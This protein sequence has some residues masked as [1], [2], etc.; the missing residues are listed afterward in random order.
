MK[1][2]ILL[3]AILLS[4]L[5]TMKYTPPLLTTLLL[6]FMS[7]SP[8]VAAEVFH[9]TMVAS[10][11][12][13]PMEIS[14]APDG[15][16][17]VIERAGRLLRVHP[18]TGAIHVAGHVRVSHYRK[19]EEGSA[20]GRECGLLG[21]ALAPDFTMTGHIY[22]YYS[23]PDRLVNH[24]SRFAMKNAL[25]DNASEQVLL[26]VAT[27]RDKLA[28]HMAGSLLFGADGCL[29][30]ATGDNTNPFES[31]GH[32]PIDDRAGQEHA[33]AMRASSNSNDLRGKILRIRP[34]AAGYDIP[35]G[36]LFP[37]GTPATKPEIYVMGCR[38]P[39]RLSMDE[40]SNTLYWG[41]VG[42]DADQPSDRG[43]RGFDEIN[44]AA[45]AGNYGWPLVIADN[46]PYPIVDFASGKIGPM[47]DPAAPH[48]PSQF[49][50]GLKV[51]PPARPA[52]IWYP[53]AE[54]KEFP[55]MGSGGRNAMAGP[56][57][58]FD[59]S[60]RFN[61][62]GADADRT[63]ITYDWMR[64]RGWKVKLDDAQKFVR[65][66][67]LLDGLMHPIDMAIAP[68]GA[69]YV[70]EYGSEWYWN[71]NGRLRRILLLQPQPAPSIS[72]TETAPRQFTAAASAGAEIRWFVTAGQQDESVGS[73]TAITLT[74]NDVREV[75]AVATDKS[76]HSA[77]ARRTLDITTQPQITLRLAGNPAKAAFGS[78]LE[79]EVTGAT[80]PKSIVTRARYIPPTGHDA[81]GPTLPAGAAKIATA[82][83]CFAC[84]QVDAPSV[85]PRYVDVAMRYHDDPTAAE[86]LSAKLKSGGAGVWGQIP[87]P[88]Q[89]ALT[90]PEAAEIIPA[91]LALTNG[92]SETRG[93]ATGSLR[94]PAAPSAA[95]PGGAW[96]IT[97]EALGY[98]SAKLRIG[99]E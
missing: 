95:A 30:L 33:N 52:F 60:R 82:R 20:W 2:T 55:L 49:N 86:K 64:G 3:S 80:D 34:T 28:T 31:G 54:S 77:F 81:G 93:N 96:E 51:L 7:V 66:E 69:L 26:T 23:H 42:P 73:G 58:Y 15:D 43:P 59:A 78:A 85:G 91:I 53:Y 12:Q 75:R 10:D 61:L 98:N 90:E 83:Q 18:P 65:M 99:A 72:I 79:F 27:E 39:F 4:K 92:M 41:E 40:K 22:L 94:L 29:Y 71:K 68:D 9:Q 5:T 97:A 24:L 6:A 50:T 44:Q 14:V 88:P 46:Q 45:T 67:P 87:M 19:A 63:L 8:S 70:L 32:A 37:P 1:K 36:N 56:V 57:F 11:L 48:N 13:D 17:Y 21:M 76:G 89:I 25:L 62:L 74:R 38:N 35:T 84:H 16:V 47:T